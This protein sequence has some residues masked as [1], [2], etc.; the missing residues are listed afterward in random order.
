MNKGL[1]LLAYGGLFASLLV[2]GAIT[3]RADGPKPPSY[4]FT[5]LSVAR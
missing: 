4:D 5:A 1:R 3:V 2:A